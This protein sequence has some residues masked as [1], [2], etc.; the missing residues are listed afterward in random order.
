MNVL[1]NNILVSTPDT[2]SLTL[3][4]TLVAD[5]DNALVGTDIQGG[6]GR[7]IVGTGHPG[8]VITAVLDPGLTLGGAAFTSSRSG[9]A[10][11]A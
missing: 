4:H 6:S 9:A 3:Q 7:I 11:L 2:Q 10:A 8:S 1:N 5:A